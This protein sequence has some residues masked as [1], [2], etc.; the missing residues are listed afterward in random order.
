VEPPEYPADA[1]ATAKAAV[2]MTSPLEAEL[3]LDK[4]RWDAIEAFQGLDYFN[5]NTIYAYL[6]KLLLMERRSLFKT[7]E[8]FAEY[9]GLYASIMEAGFTE[10]N[11]KAEENTNG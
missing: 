3:F 1:A 9:K 7:E 10:G 4:A 2:A 5:R 11:S 6:L 8:G